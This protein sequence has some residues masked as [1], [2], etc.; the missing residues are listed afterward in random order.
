[1]ELASSRSALCCSTPTSSISHYGREFSFHLLSFFQ[2]SRPVVPFLLILLPSKGS[3]RRPLRTNVP[4]RSCCCPSKGKKVQPRPYHMDG[5]GRTARPTTWL[6]GVGSACCGNGSGGL[7][8]EEEPPVP[9]V[10][11]KAELPGRSP[12]PRSPPFLPVCLDR[13]GYGPFDD[14]QLVQLLRRMPL[15]S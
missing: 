9:G 14:E 5:R 2:D 10:L 6:R 13:G 7:I 4:P 12:A 11:G 3:P 1:M 15:V 8:A